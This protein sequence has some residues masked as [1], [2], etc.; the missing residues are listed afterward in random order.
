MIV[1]IFPNPYNINIF[2]QKNKFDSNKAKINE[3]I[4]EN[5]EDKKIFIR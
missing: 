3:I 5:D 4:G 2:Q 1:K